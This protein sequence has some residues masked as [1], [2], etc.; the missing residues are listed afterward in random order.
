MPGFKKFFMGF[1]GIIGIVI[2]LAGPLLI[3]SSLN[4]VANNNN[5]EGATITL[6]MVVKQSGVENTYQLFKNDHVQYIDIISNEYY[7]QLKFGE[8]PNMRNFDKSTIQVIALSRFADQN[9]DITVPNQQMLFDQ[10][11]MVKDRDP[12]APTIE[13]QLIYTFSRPEPPG[14]QLTQKHIEKVL[15]MDKY[16]SMVTAFHHALDPKYK[17]D[18]DP[19]DIIVPNFY[20][21]SIR[22]G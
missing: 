18:L 4:P 6:N 7:N 13:V 20:I 16:E 14:Q 21:P 10:V 2:L 12:D 5:V 8:E 17:C 19:T 9:W 1:I 15:N 3:F 11:G 22:L